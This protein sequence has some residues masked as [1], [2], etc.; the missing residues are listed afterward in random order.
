MKEI[1]LH[2][3]H[4]KTGSSYLQSCLAL[5][6]KKLLDLGID[7][8]EDLSFKSAKKGEITSGNPSQFFNN[9]LNIES[10]TDKEIILF[11][12]EGFY[13]TLNHLRAETKLKSFNHLKFFEKYSN[14]LKVILYTRNLFSHFFSIWA[15]QVKRSSLVSGIDTFLKN[16]PS[17]DCFLIIDWLNLSKKFGFQLI[18]R[19]YSN[20]KSNLLN[21]F[22]E[23]VIGKKAKNMNFILPENKIV[24]RSLTFSEY[25]IQ[26]IC[27]FLNM[28]KPPLSDFLINQLP[29]IKPMEIKCSMESYNIIKDANI[30][31]INTI[32]NKINK[33]EAI[34]IESP[35]QVVYKENEFQNPPLTEDQIKIIASYIDKKFLSK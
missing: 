30:E 24:N 28:S 17:S 21:I 8:P 2:I 9:H 31:I 1:I 26:R 18:I 4:G 15:Q 10:I 20:H 7:Y 29:N 12:N 25:E 11:S 27:N 5:N 35:E 19:N 32:N 23:D 3:G 6:R 13:G 33:N 16:R 34:K 22:F 14:K